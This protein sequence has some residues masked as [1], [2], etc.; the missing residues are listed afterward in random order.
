MAT[1]ANDV[2]FEEMAAYQGKTEELF[3]ATKSSGG[4]DI[5]DSADDDS[6]ATLTSKSDISDV[7]M[8]DSGSD[9]T[10]TT[11]SNNVITDDASSTMTIRNEENKNGDSGGT[12]AD[13]DVGDGTPQVDSRLG[14]GSKPT[15]TD[16]RRQ[17]K[18]T[19]SQSQLGDG[20]RE[21]RQ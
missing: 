19:V 18:R 1:H 21:Y 15:E 13:K 17:R 7:I 4:D 9:L 11:G 10:S 16:R 6:N 5:M 12:D 20:P 14:P 8:D 2:K 3:G